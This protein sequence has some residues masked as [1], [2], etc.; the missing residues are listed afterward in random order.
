[1]STTITSDRTMRESVER[2]LDW[3]AQ[4]LA[5]HVAVSANDGAIVLTG[6]VPTYVDRW[7]AGQAAERVYGVRAV[8]NEIDVRIP[9]SGKRDDSDIAEDIT[10]IMHSSTV[11]LPSVK[12]EVKQGSVTL[13][14]EVLWPFQRTEA[15]RVLRHLRGVRNI[16]NTITV[17]PVVPAGVDIDLRVKQAIER[18]AHLDARSIRA[19]TTNGTV[20]LRGHVHSFAEK[21]T[22]GLAAASAP[23][24]INVENDVLVTP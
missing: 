17:K 6:H 7:E 20:H 11:I 24:V 18:M 12:A 21:H 3:D 1:M 23:G 8:V 10:Q 22:A 19:T 5:T 4:V 2:E 16:V 15:S 9:A 14:G 13:I